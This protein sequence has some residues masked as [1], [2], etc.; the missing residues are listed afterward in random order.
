MKYSIKVKY[1]KVISKVP[2]SFKSL[3]LSVFCSLFSSSKRQTSS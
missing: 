2:S 1:C 3:R